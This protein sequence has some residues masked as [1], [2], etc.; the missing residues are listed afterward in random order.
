MMKSGKAFIK[1]MVNVPQ[2]YILVSS[3]IKKLIFDTILYV[4]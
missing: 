2:I 1:P 3:F 4:C